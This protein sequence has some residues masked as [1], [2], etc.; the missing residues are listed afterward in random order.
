MLYYGLGYRSRTCSLMLPKQADYQFSQS[1]ISASIYGL[2]N[3]PF[4]P[5]FKDNESQFK[6][7]RGL[8]YVVSI[9][10]PSLSKGR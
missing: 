2:A 9:P 3:A 4:S 7:E 6:I 5:P 1:E 10:V 8:E